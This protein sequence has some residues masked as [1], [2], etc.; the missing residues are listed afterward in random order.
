MFRDLPGRSVQ[1]LAW[2]TLWILS[3]PVLDA[4]VAGAELTLQQAVAQAVHANTEIRIA[5]LETAKAQDESSQARSVYLPRLWVS[6]NAGYSSRL[7]KKLRAVDRNGR[8]RT[9]GLASLGATRG[10]FNAGVDQVLFDVRR[11]I[12]ANQTQ[13][14]A[15]AAGVAE[16]ARRE[17]IVAEVVRRYTDVLRLQHHLRLDKQHVTQAVQL[18]EQAAALA[19]VGK[20]LATD[21]ELAALGVDAARAAREARTADLTSARESLMRTIGWGGGN[22]SAPPALVEQSLP[23]TGTLST[24]R[25]EDA[26]LSQTPDVKLLGLRAQMEE[27]NVQAARAERLPTVAL[28]GEYSNFGPK[29]FDNFQDEFRLGVEARLTLFDG[30]QT[31][32]AIAKAEKGLAVAR[33]RHDAALALRREQIDAMIRRLAAARRSTELAARRAVDAK[34]RLRL[35]G[36][37]LRTGQNTIATA[38]DALEGWARIAHA[39]VD[40]R[41]DQ[42]VL[43]SRLEHARGRLAK[44]LGSPAAGS[45][46]MH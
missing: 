8:E 13:R 3:F 41:F 33:L 32:N 15:E 2:V 16:A 22:T 46:P 30:L 18:R 31:R 35:A 10:F 25:I 21:I 34:E 17:E 43:W 44:T 7:N 11:W 37:R 19:K 28:T 20:A 39:A 27:Q 1:R 29:R 14:G 38:A 26:E 36:I 9:F 23:D 42:F 40:A 6:S 5:A 24:G 12:E 45:A 4:P